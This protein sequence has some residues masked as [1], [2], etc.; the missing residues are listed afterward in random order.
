MIKTEHREFT[1]RFEVRVGGHSNLNYQRKW[2]AHDV[3]EKVDKFNSLVKANEEL[4][5]FDIDLTPL[6]N[7]VL[8]HLV[9]KLQF[10]RQ[11]I[12]QDYALFKDICQVFK[13]NF[14][15]IQEPRDFV[16]VIKTPT[17]M[18]LVDGKT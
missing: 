10:D 8:S 17:M 2:H 9:E 18:K 12:R 4:L 5:D 11:S 13:G 16:P 3:E 7:R 15:I 6:Q 1:F 14:T